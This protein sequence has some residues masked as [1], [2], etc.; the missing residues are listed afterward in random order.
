LAQT[1]VDAIVG[2]RLAA[3]RTAQGVNV[4]QLAS[5]L[6]T[7]A[8]QIVRYEAGTERVSA[9]H[10]I[11]MCQFFQVSIADLFPT[12]DPDHDRKLH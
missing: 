9:T 3:I 6:G 1:P 8:D 4:S 7:T 5:A 11:K 2:A 10:L 12:S